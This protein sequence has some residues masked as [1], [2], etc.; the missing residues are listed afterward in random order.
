MSL[1][2][3]VPLKQNHSLL[4]FIFCFRQHCSSETDRW[5]LCPWVFPLGYLCQLIFPLCVAVVPQSGSHHSSLINGVPGLRLVLAPPPA[6]REKMKTHSW[7][8][9]K[10]SLLKLAL[11]FWHIPE[12]NT[13]SLWHTKKAL[14]LTG[15]RTTGGKH[16]RYIIN[17]TGSEAETS[18]EGWL[19][20]FMP[21]KTQEMC[22]PETCTQIQAGLTTLQHLTIVQTNPKEKMLRQDI[23]KLA[24][25]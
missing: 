10:S 9:Y 3:A 25:I 14:L 24:C 5:C 22:T 2:C 8:S 1:G 12:E 21:K 20:C 7:I 23:A 16:V 11:L 17:P 18:Q 19:G 6:L 15:P 13:A 4:H